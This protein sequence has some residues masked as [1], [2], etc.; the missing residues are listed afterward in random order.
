MQMVPPPLLVKRLIYNNV[1]KK[2]IS[3]TLLF[4]GIVT[5]GLFA[6]SPQAHAVSGADWKPGRIIDD[7]VFQ[8]KN[9]MTV[10]QIQQF[11]DSKVP[12]CDTNGSKPMWAG[13]P[14]RAQWSLDNGRDPAPYTCLKDYI[15][16]PSTKLNNADNPALPIPG[17]IPAAQL[18]YNAAQAQNINPQVLMVLLQKEQGLITDE[19]P[20][21]SQFER[22]TGN[23]CPDTAPCDSQYAWLWTQVNNAA[24]Q[25]NYYVNHFDQFNYAP[26]WNNILNSPSAGCGTQRIFIENAYTAALYIYTPYAPNQPALDNMY[27]LGDGC[28]A[29]GNRNFWRMFNDWF[30][31]SVDDVTA[32]QVFAHP[33]GTLI[34]NPTEQAVYVIENGSRRHINSLEKFRSF[35]FTFERVM[36]PTLADKSLPIGPPMQKF[37]EGTILSVEGG[38]R[39]DNYMVTTISD[40]SQVFHKLTEQVLISEKYPRRRIISVPLSQ[41][42]TL[43]APIPPNTS[44]ANG[45]LVI[46][47]SD[48]KVYVIDNGFRRHIPSLNSL[49]SNRFYFDDAVDANVY[50]LSLPLGTPYPMGEGSLV[51]DQDGKIS[52]IDINLEG[53]QTLRHIPALYMFVGLGYNWT[54]PYRLDITGVLVGPVL[55]ASL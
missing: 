32:S 54:Y 49:F 22:A 20:Y 28:S 36:K 33:D 21:Q 27:G 5:V 8:N 15:E 30:G 48:L 43:G 12:V 45:T 4:A 42:G 10:A 26:G 14:T 52:T 55:T 11:L 46:D 9:S 37:R 19:W 7:A 53:I 39:D 2:L 35:R 1:M 18:I 40:E 41:I 13:G 6:H 3:T 25:F 24:V 16:N 44:H 31:P 47:R 23:H 38:S 34:R 17:G 29:Y 51:I 50:D